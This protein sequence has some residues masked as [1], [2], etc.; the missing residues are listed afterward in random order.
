MSRA[1]RQHQA[2]VS[3]P[4]NR[5]GSGGTGREELTPHQERAIV[6]LLH[7]PG[8]TAA[9]KEAGV[10]KTTLW[11]WM[12]QPTFREAYRRARREAY[13]TAVARL[14]QVAG[15]AVETLR[16][17]MVDKSQQ[18]AARVGAAK[19][20]LDYAVKAAEVEDL[21]AKVEELETKVG[22]AA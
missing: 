1:E 11:T 19:A 5:P 15:Q 18:G 16:E 8:L 3:V 2:P 22:G 10:G 20:V 13:A 9:A 4:V 6:A 14:Q 17:V 12:Q 21:S 7:Q